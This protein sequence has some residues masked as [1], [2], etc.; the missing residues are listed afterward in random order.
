[1]KTPGTPRLASSLSKAGESGGGG[2]TP[3]VP[4]SLMKRSIDWLFAGSAKKRKTTHHVSNDNANVNDNANGLDTS[5]SLPMTMTNND[6][7][8]SSPLN[9]N[10]NRN[11]GTVTGTGTG[12]TYDATNRNS[13]SDR[14]V[15]RGAAASLK[16]PSFHIGSST[17]SSTTNPSFKR[18]TFAANVK[19]ASTPTSNSN[20]TNRITTPFPGK[21]RQTLRQPQTPQQ[22][23]QQRTARRGT[24]Y[25]YNKRST[26]KFATPGK[27][28]T[29][30]YRKTP[31]GK[32]YKPTSKILTASIT[33]APTS[34]QSK[35]S[36]ISTTNITSVA[37][38]ILQKS[39][40][41]HGRSH[42]AALFDNPT[43]TRK[44]IKLN[45]VLGTNQTGSRI[46]TRNQSEG[47]TGI[48]YDH[49]E[50]Q[51]AF[52]GKDYWS[53]VQHQ[54]SVTPPPKYQDEHAHEDEEIVVQSAKRKKVSFNNLTP[55][56]GRSSRDMATPVGIAPRSTEKKMPLMAT[57]FKIV[58]QKK[59]AN[60]HA[61][62]D[63]GYERDE[64]GRVVYGS[65]NM[66][67]VTLELGIGC[68]GVEES[69]VTRIVLERLRKGELNGDYNFSNKKKIDDCGNDDDADGASSSVVPYSFMP[70]VDS[71]G[72]KGSSSLLNKPIV[73]EPAAKEEANSSAPASGGWG[74]AFAKIPGEWKC[75]V[76][77]TKSPK[78]ASACLACEHPKGKKAA[79]AAK[80]D[81]DA[82][83]APDPAPAST[84][85]SFMDDKKDDKPSTGGFTFGAP[86]VDDKKD[87][88]PSTGGFTFG[89]PKVDDKKDNEPATGGFTF[90][91]PKVDDKKDNE[92]APG[93]F[94]FGAPKVDDKEKNEPAT[95]GFTLAAQP[96]SATE[97]KKESAPKPSF[98]FGSTPAP[99]PVSTVD[100][101]TD[102]APKSVFSF[103][104]TPATKAN[105]GA[106]D[107]P[108]TAFSFGSI[109]AAEKKDS[110]PVPPMAFGSLPSSK[111]GND[112]K[113]KRSS[114][115]AGDIAQPSPAST[116]A[117]SFG[118]ATAQPSSV[119][120]SKPSFSFGSS[121]AS[122]VSV[123][124]PAADSKP[125]FTF[126]AGGAS[127]APAADNKPSFTFGSGGAS[128]STV[129][130][131]AASSQ[132][133]F[134]SSA[135]AATQLVPAQPVAPSGSFAFGSTPAAA[136]AA[137]APFA[138]G[139]AAAPPQPVQ[140]GAPA[141]AASGGFGF[142]QQ[143]A[144]AAPAFGFAAPVPAAPAQFGAPIAPAQFGGP[145]APA[146]PAQF[147]A[148]VAPTAPAQFGAPAAPA[149][150]GGGGFGQPT[151]PPM[152][153]GGFS[154]GKS[155]GG[156][157]Q[158]RGRRI[159][160]A[161]RPP[162]AR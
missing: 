115:V 127:A 30:T 79:D 120:E 140:F 156:K 67:G 136:P 141:P 46:Q 80:N 82:L 5:T 78:E 137:A 75:D 134:G 133:A 117:F 153:G 53:H 138:F 70:K 52:G 84:K 145:V 41:Q 40:T 33:S 130:P 97:K 161:K 2:G 9:I 157:Q 72:K 58:E 139:G 39:K 128:I 132:F 160:R 51:K 83:A 60:L 8:F 16:T 62:G 37:S 35:L 152:G 151:A 104:S 59:Y 103:G 159:I 143:Q 77:S 50:A 99:V 45:R 124:V 76:C 126:G 13:D 122:T 19:S 85:F 121:G 91:A 17:L 149:Q 106:A 43:H 73:A 29:R 92:P 23:Q 113:K 11:T 24:P 10:S 98:T 55:P 90:G 88:K 101:K 105:E 26:V 34:T 144:P 110:A 119:T 25:A 18:I 71:R 87:D 158:G 86:K 108:K 114:D 74:N 64:D 102:S 118:S 14:N 69:D 129:P 28:N 61:D 4:R 147:G 38:Q 146:A 96:S 68:E 21:Q 107:A 123:A 131:P 1:M 109:P 22:K 65:E 148:P 15:N 154:I 89:A 63:G 162:G 3:E 150:F 42:D 20:H 56:G 7:P 81:K 48:D 31:F 49:G 12:T 94:T 135:P 116:P 111:D 66:Y 125:S 54:D 112:R 57:P 100:S 155:G 36:H 32:K 27:T 95:V 47:Y 44:S 6:N 93:G 142:G